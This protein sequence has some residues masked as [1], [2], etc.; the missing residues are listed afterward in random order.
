M[1]KYLPHGTLVSFNAV[2]IGG[3]TSVGIP[4]RTRGEV[5][6]TDSNS[7]GDR[8]YIPGLREGGSVSLTMRHDPADPGQIQLENNFTS[9]AS[10]SIKT[11]V[12]TLPAAAKSPQRTYT[13]SGFVSTA[14]SGD[15]G[16]VDD[17]AAS[18]SATIKVAGPVT[19]A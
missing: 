16:L 15:L 19:I 12:I 7:A 10:N 13:F 5:E 6:T 1:A 8:T 18:Q 3:L 2:N 9:D 17:D 11:V 14:P 4:E